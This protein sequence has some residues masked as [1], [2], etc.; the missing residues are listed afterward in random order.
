VSVRPSVVTQ[1]VATKVRASVLEYHKAVGS[2]Q[3]HNQV[4]QLED[5]ESEHAP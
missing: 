4:I 5:S 3:R 2:G 1:A